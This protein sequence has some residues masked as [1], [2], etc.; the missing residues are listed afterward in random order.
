MARL[1]VDC[2]H[3]RLSPGRWGRRVCQAPTLAR[4][5]VVT[6]DLF[7]RDCE[8]AR[9]VPGGCGPGGILWLPI[10]SPP[11]PAPTLASVH[12]PGLFA[13]TGAFL[14]LIVALL[15]GAALWILFAST[16]GLD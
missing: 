16:L 10:E 11:T 8:V 5:N 15:A 7:Y 9:T 3:H 6:G 13:T 4:R 14:G 2:A 1:C 12:E